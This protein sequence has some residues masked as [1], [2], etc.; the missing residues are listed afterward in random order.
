MKTAREFRDFFEKIPDTEW[1]ITDSGWC[2]AFVLLGLTSQHAKMNEVARRLAVIAWS[3]GV[4]V[5]A[6]CDRIKNYNRS[7][8][9]LRM[10]AM[11]DDAIAK[12]L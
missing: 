5:T 8:P 2:A 10:I 7:T 11:L 9:R 6:T 1:P 3:I 12:G 4:G